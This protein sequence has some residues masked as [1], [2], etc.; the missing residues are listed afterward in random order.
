MQ[1]Q[2]NQ[3]QQQ[4]KQNN[5]FLVW[6]VEKLKNENFRKNRDRDLLLKRYAH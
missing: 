5:L 6:R 3:Q 4:P 2:T 1:T